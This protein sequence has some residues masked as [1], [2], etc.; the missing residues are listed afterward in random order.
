MDFYSKD[1][2][3]NH[4]KNEIELWEQSKDI[5]EVLRKAGYEILN[6]DTLLSKM[7][8]KHLSEIEFDCRFYIEL[9]NG[10]LNKA[11]FCARDI[12]TNN[13]FGYYDDEVIDYMGD[14]LIDSCA[15]TSLMEYMLVTRYY[16]DKKEYQDI[17]AQLDVLGLKIRDYAVVKKEYEAYFPHASHL[18]D[19]LEDIE[20][21]CKYGRKLKVKSFNITKKDFL[22]WRKPRF[23]EANPTKVVSKVWEYAMRTRKGACWI[24]GPSLF[25]ESPGWCFD[26]FGKSLTFMPDGREIHIAGEHEDYYD[27]DFYIY[28]DVIVVYPDDTVEFYNYPEEVFPPTD[29]HSATLVD[30]KIIIIGSLGY[31][32]EGKIDTTQILVLDT[33]NFKIEPVESFGS[34]PGWIHKHKAILSDDKKHIKIVGGKIDLGGKAS[35]VENIDEWELDLETWQWSRLTHR[36]W[37]Q[38]EFKKPGF[39]RNNLFKI[40]SALFSLEAGWEKEYKK[41]IKTLT[42]E[43]EF[44]PNVALVKELYLPDIEHKIIEMDKYT[45]TYIFSVKGVRVRFNEDMSSIAMTI[46]GELDSKY[47]EAVKNS[48][49]SKLK[50][51]E[52]VDFIFREIKRG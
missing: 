26:R 22:E 24:G 51:L 10:I 49:L 46:E 6:D 28:N 2:K 39:T 38:F 32:S 17:R 33:K 48:V 52:G 5:Q 3:M 35:L 30:D 34:K 7:M 44:E 27:P 14:E 47:I 20:E 19:K 37:R 40:R 25:K 16:K 23:G 21:T 8:Q 12:K 15:N 4:L 1:Y 42:K 18:E 31:G 9:F 13:L 36:K 41:E 11:S 50:E 45:D 43:I 29:F